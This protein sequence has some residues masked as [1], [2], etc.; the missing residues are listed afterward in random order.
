MAAQAEEIEVAGRAVRLTSRDRVIFPERG[1][2]KGDVFDYY[3]AV[4]EGIMRALDRRPTTLQ[5]FPDGVDGEA[6]GFRYLLMPRRL[7]S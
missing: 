2:T 6:S 1:Y 3:V 7:L 4:G 5:R